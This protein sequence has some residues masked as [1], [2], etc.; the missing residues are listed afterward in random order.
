MRRSIAVIL[1]IAICS[2]ASTPLIA[3]TSDPYKN[4]PACCRR[5][6]KHHCMM[7]MQEQVSSTGVSV[8][9]EKCPM[10][11]K[12]ILPG[13][14]RAIWIAPLV[15]RPLFVQ[16]LSY[17]AVLAQTEAHYRISYNRARLKRGPP[18]YSTPAHI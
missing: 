1:L 6:G 3:S 5:L 10:F 17:P 2:L 7:V 13:T 16:A 11:P 12:G 18:A 15:R 9:A 14:V 4:L 8:P